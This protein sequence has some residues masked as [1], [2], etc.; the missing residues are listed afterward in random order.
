MILRTLLVEL[1]AKA[2]CA[3]VISFW[4]EVDGKAK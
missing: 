1:K 3:A 4:V 2:C